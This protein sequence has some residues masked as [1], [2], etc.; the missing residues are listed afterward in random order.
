MLSS[1]KVLRI[2]SNISYVCLV[3]TTI[4]ATG[5]SCVALLGQAVR[6]SPNRS[7]TRNYNALV[8]GASYAVVLAFS[9]IYCVNRRFA[10]RMRL[11]RISKTHT[12]IRRGDVPN[13]VHEYITQEYMRTCLVSHESL[14][15]DVFHAGW[16]RPGTKYEG[17]RFRRAL[18]DTIPEIDT[19]AHMVIPAHP[20]LKPHAR[21]LHHFRFILPLLNAE[22]EEFTPLHYYDSAIQLARNA[23]EEPTEPE[24]VLGM[25][26]AEEIKKSLS[27][28]VQ[29]ALESSITDF[30]SSES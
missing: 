7:W 14:P 27:D 1:S 3:I 13:P 22:D 25:Q 30:E 29:E 8:I 9:L 4:I 17:V 23:A 28:C 15:A 26:A 6:H 24:F 19:L 12:I 21:M 20:V 16:G 18:L 5:L 10:V 11:G 2:F